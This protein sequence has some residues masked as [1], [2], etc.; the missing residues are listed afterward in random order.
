MR[1]YKI[2]IGTDKPTVFDSFPNGMNNPAAMQVY[3]DIP[4]IGFGTPIGGALI[5]IWGIPLSYISSAMNFNNK[6]IK[7]TGGMQKGLPLANPKQ[8]GILVQGYIY[9]AFANWQGNEQSLDLIAYFGDPPADPNKP[10]KNISISW[11]KSQPLADT[12]KSILQT[13]MGTGWTIDVQISDS[14]VFSENLPFAYTNLTQFGQML[15]QFSKSIITDST[16]LGVQIVPNGTKK[17][18]VFDGTV[19]SSNQP[20]AIDFNDLI[21][22][23][24]WIEK[25]YINFKT[26]LRGDLNVNTPIT[27]PKG[28]ATIAL[29]TASAQNSILNLPSNFSGNFNISDL[30][31][32]G[33]FRNPDASSWVTVVNAYP[34]TGS[35]AA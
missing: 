30:R 2:E 4:T 19:Q 23:P 13:A 16:Y 34:S 10:Q 11:P 3:F 28:L 17:L 26:V 14:L 5:R 15:L 31:H 22:Q 27:L 20:T 8:I 29:T 25:P 9:Q 33:D 18:L 35:P 24:T 6:T 32:I 12:V 1:Y 7:V 21:G